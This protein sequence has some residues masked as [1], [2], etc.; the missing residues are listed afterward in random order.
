MNDLLAA[1][2]ALTA[3]TTENGTTRPARLTTLR[4]AIAA[5]TSAGGGKS[6][7]NERIPL[8]PHALETYARIRDA[9]RV[10]YRRTGGKDD[11]APEAAL[12]AWYI[13]AT[14]RGYDAHYL[15]EWQHRIEGWVHELDRILDPV[16]TLE[17]LDTPCIACGK[18]EAINAAGELQAAIVV[19]YRR[20][21]DDLADV[22]TLCRA[23]RA[24]WEGK[25]GA[26]SFRRY[27]EEQADDAQPYVVDVPA[28]RGLKFDGALNLAREWL[29]QA[30]Q[31]HGRIRLTHTPK[32][33]APRWTFTAD[34]RDTRD[35][36]GATVPEWGQNAIA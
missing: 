9:I 31:L 20:A 8:D 28:A 15:D 16:R 17:L 7:P 18:A 1:V 33:G 12:R 27:A 10:E 34:V 29:E 22:R 3:P 13:A 6:L 2:D 25:H 23:C 19:E 11:R 32:P 24:V 21:G 5:S 36:D 26:S 4:A 35:D 14:S 30:G